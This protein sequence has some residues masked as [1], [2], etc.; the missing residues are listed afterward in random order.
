MGSEGKQLDLAGFSDDGELV[1]ARQ[2]SDV[3]RRAFCSLSLPA[4]AK[5]AGKT[6]VCLHL[7]VKEKA[8]AS[9]RYDRETPSLWGALGSL[10]RF[11]HRTTKTEWSNDVPRPCFFL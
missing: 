5:C 9:R 2:S 10:T 11:I 4:S 6:R 1:A 7:S 3:Q 8:L